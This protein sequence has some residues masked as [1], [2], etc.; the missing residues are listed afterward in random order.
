MRYYLANWF[1]VLNG[2]VG[3]IMILPTLG[4][5]LMLFLY[6]D[7]KIDYWERNY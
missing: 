3:I 6:I 4:A 1:R 5:W 2:I 7:K